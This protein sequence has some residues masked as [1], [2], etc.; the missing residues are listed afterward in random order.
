MLEN[1]GDV[2]KCKFSRPSGE[3]SHKSKQIFQKTTILKINLSD[4]KRFVGF[5]RESAFQAF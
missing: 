4:L 5:L 2:S 3:K 1:E